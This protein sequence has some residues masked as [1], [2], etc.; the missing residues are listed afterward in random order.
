[1]LFFEGHHTGELAMAIITLTTD[2]GLKDHYVAVVKGTIL[3]LFP[4]AVVVDVSHQITP[5]DNA[6]TAFALRN[7]YPAFPKGTV[8]AIGVNPGADAQTPHL[9]VLHDGH[10]FVGADNGI[11]SL[12]F[13]GKPQALHTLRM[14]T[15]PGDAAFPVKGVLARAACHLAQGGAVEAIAET[16]LNFR[17][18][19]GFH[20]GHGPRKHP[21]VVVHVDTYGNANHQH[22]PGPIRD[23]GEGPAFPH[24]FRAITVRYH[25]AEPDLRRGAARRTRRAVRRRRYAGD[26]GEQGCGRQRW[27]RIAA[28]RAACAGSRSRGT[29][30]PAGLGFMIVRLVRM[31]F[32]EEGMA[33]FQELFE[34]WRHRI[35]ASPGCLHLELLHDVGDPRVFFTY[36]VWRS[37]ED[38]GTLPPLGRIRPSMAHGEGDVRRTRPGLVLPPPAYDG[39]PTFRPMIRTPALLLA[40]LTYPALAQTSAD[41]LLSAQAAYEA[42]ALDSALVRVERAI[43]ADKGSAAAYKLRGDIRQ[44]NQQLEL[45][46]IDYK[47]SEIL[48]PNN[49]RLYVSRS[50]ARITEGNVKGA[51]RDLEKAIELDPTV[52]D[53]YYNRACAHYLLQD[54]RPV[55]IG[56]RVLLWAI[57]TRSLS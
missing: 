10:W 39:R 23:L 36:S 24:H 51:L 38:F 19:L 41:L 25:C 13:D 48:D 34:G 45:A 33:Q 11:F 28:V 50:A 14:V 8:H 22:P 30:R 31:T 43:D 18:Q 2:M 4:Q 29:P 27:R 56:G 16:T 44:R 6:Q 20:P 40:L 37:A 49:P 57:S 17:Q 55:R 46:L 53:A 7:A 32:Q 5:F 47:E 3:G 1:M 54:R 52:A 15:E 21:R 12:L 42:G 26:R 35:I 9:A